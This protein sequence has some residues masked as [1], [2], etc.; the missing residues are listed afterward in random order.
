MLHCL[1]SLRHIHTEWKWTRKQRYL[2]IAETKGNVNSFKFCGENQKL[3]AFAIAFN[4]ARCENPLD[5]MVG[6]Y[7]CTNVRLMLRAQYHRQ[8][9]DLD[10]KL[11]SIDLWADIFLIVYLF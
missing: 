3:F 8:T 11:V 6:S 7:T 9:I 2:N 1:A 10:I 5:N 4:F